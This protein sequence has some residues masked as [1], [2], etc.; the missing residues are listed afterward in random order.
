[1]HYRLVVFP[2]GTSSREATWLRAWLGWPFAGTMLAVLFTLVLP[3]MVPVLVAVP[4]AVALL[5]CGHLGLLH[6]VRRQ[7]RGVCVVRAEYVA[8]AGV[9]DELERC[10]HLEAVGAIL[11]GAERAVECG[12]LTPVDFELLWASLHAQ[13]GALA[14]SEPPTS[15]GT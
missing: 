12:D 2:P 9:R 14:A 15:S 10:R 5:F 3:G 13:V 8:G 4:I 6:V 11:L 1:M 7:R